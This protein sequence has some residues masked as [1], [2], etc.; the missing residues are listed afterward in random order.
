MSRQKILQIL[1]ISTKF[2][3]IWFNLCCFQWCFQILKIVNYHCASVDLQVTGRRRWT[4]SMYIRDLQKQHSEICTWKLIINSI[5]RVILNEIIG[6]G[7]RKC[8][9]SEVSNNKFHRTPHQQYLSRCFSIPIEYVQLWTRNATF[10][11]RT[12][13]TTLEATEKETGH[14]LTYLKFRIKSGEYKVEAM[15]AL[16]LC[17]M[18]FC[19]MSHFRNQ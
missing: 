5:F 9:E 18:M 7:A 4:N 1:D 16:D 11:T 10:V 2:A 19:N 6:W 13:M 15:K 17:Q 14:S 3:W 8:F 12:E